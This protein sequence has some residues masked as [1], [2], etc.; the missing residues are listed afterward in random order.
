MNTVN[1][2]SFSWLND[3]NERTGIKILDKDK[4]CDWLI[5]G[6]GYTGKGSLYRSFFYVC[7]QN[8]Q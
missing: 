2:N 8:F 3:L 7:S 5:V 1:D 6:A 4:T